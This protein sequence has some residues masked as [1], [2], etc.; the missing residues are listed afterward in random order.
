MYQTACDFA[1]ISKNGSATVATKKEPTTQISMQMTKDPHAHAIEC[2]KNGLL[3]QLPQLSFTAETVGEAF[4]ATLIAQPKNAPDILN[5]LWET[6]PQVSWSTQ[7]ILSR[8]VL[9]APKLA[10]KIFAHAFETEPQRLRLVARNIAFHAL[11]SDTPHLLT[12]VLPYLSASA[13]RELITHACQNKQL[14]LAKRVVE[15]YPAD[16][17]LDFLKDVSRKHR[18]EVEY[19]LSYAQARRIRKSL[20]DIPCSSSKSTTRKI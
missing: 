16:E 19:V 5:Y 9:F 7:L 17:S 3:E 13:L 10:P 4:L 15:V 1:L 12:M 11:R 6:H 20:E 8:V 2:C 18:Q 14:P